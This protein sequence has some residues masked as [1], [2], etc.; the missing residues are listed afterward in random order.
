MV[1]EWAFRAPM[2]VGVR[3]ELTISLSTQSLS[4]EV[5]LFAAGYLRT[6]TIILS[7]VKFS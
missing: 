4:R 3:P 2:Q 7:F 5:E 1:A 6:I